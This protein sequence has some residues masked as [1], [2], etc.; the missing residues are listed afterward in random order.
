[1]AD[2]ALAG[3]DAHDNAA[4]SPAAIEQAVRNR[5]VIIGLPKILEVVGL[6]RA[7]RDFQ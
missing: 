7:R 4:T 3:A 5:L 6:S 2:G 1:V